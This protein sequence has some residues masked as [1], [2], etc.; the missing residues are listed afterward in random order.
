M[1]SDE[2]D[3]YRWLMSYDPKAS[4]ELNQKCI[5]QWQTEQLFK[6]LKYNLFA[7]LPKKVKDNHTEKT[8]NRQSAALNRHVIKQSDKD[9][10]KSGQCDSQS[11]KS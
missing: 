3:T 4:P 10:K 9:W 7:E 1:E 8:E 11:L 6:L 5:K 2:A